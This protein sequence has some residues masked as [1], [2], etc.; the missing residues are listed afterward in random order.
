MNTNTQTQA[1]PQE[2]PIISIQYEDHVGELINSMNALKQWTETL[3][4]T[5]YIINP[6][7]EKQGIDPISISQ[8]TPLVTILI[9]QPIFLTQIAEALTT[10]AN[11]LE[12][13]F[14]GQTPTFRNEETV[15]KNMITTELLNQ[16][17]SATGKAI[18][19]LEETVER[20]TGKDLKEPS[21][22]KPEIMFPLQQWRQ[23]PT[24]YNYLATNVYN[25]YSI[26][27]EQLAPPTK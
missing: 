25:I 27:T 2:A 11:I 7:I 20:L 26:L 15:T 4:T 21:P 8:E 14:T 22:D 13:T 1:V 9:E 16:H 17:I 23:L 19:T 24:I 6:H 5:A 3:I 12:L 18:M 10:T